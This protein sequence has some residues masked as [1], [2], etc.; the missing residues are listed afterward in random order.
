MEEL[1]FKIVVRYFHRLNTLQVHQS[2]LRF[3]LSKVEG[4]K[5]W[6]YLL[7]FCIIGAIPVTSFSQQEKLIRPLPPQ[8]SLTDLKS[9]EPEINTGYEKLLQEYGELVN[10]YPDKKE[11][12]YNLGNLNYLSGDT[13]SALQNYRNSLID[14]DPKS[15]ANT[16]YNIGNTYYQMGDLQKSVELFKEALTLAPDDEDIRYNYELSKRMLELQP[17][18][19]NQDQKQDG[20]EGNDEQK[21]DQQNQQSQK[22]D[23]QNQNSESG[24]ERDK[25]DSEDQQKSENGDENEE[26]IEEQEQSQS[27]EGDEKNEQEQNTQQSESQTRAEKEKQLGKEEAEAILNALKADEKNLKPRKYKAVGRIKLEKDW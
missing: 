2:D 7:I 3:I 21:Q 17:P 5:I 14:A 11:L 12:Y 1:R 10:K 26:K 25:E 9:K 24:E 13:E 6:R 18:Q 19:E 27:Q 20:E 16:L 15:R 23:E 8:K 22:G 4:I